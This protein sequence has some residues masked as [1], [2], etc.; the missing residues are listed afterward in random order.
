MSTEHERE[1][2]RARRVAIYADWISHDADGLVFN[3]R[4]ASSLPALHAARSRVADALTQLDAAIGE[5]RGA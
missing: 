2:A 5:A 3:A 1:T 4:Q